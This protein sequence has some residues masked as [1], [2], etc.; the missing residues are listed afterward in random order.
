MVAYS[1]LPQTV[2]VNATNNGRVVNTTN[3]G[4]VRL[5]AT[6]DEDTYRIT[7]RHPWLTQAEIT[8]LNSFYTTNS[9]SDIQITYAGVTYDAYMLGP[10][11]FRAANRNSTA[12]FH[13]TVQMIGNPQ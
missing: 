5:Q 8:T 6:N 13:A 12:Y 2:E 1:T 9:G 4:T 10:P 11:S 7:V 3:S